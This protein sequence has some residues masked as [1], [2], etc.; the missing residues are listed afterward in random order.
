MI[1]AT[2]S[3]MKKATSTMVSE[4]APLTGIASSDAP[5]TIPSTAETSAHQQPGAWR[6]QNVVI[7]PITPLTRNSQPNRIVTASVASGGMTTA[8]APR[9]S[10][11]TPSTKYST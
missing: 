2:P 1:E 4:N 9:T 5:T 6:I 7:R 11:T 10:S 3:M 8:V